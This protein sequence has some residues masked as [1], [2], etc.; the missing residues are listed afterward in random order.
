VLAALT[1]AAMCTALAL[2]PTPQ[3]QAY[4]TFADQRAWLSVPHFLNVVSSAALVLAGAAG[5]WFI[6]GHASASAASTCTQRWD[7]RPYGVF[8]LGALLTGFGS[9]WYHWAPDSARLTWDRLPITLIFMSLLA[10]TVGER[11]SASGARLGL[12]P[13]L[14]LGLASVIFWQLGEQRGAGDL[15]LY[16]L[17]QFHTALMIPLIALLFPS[18]HGGDHAIMQAI[19]LYALAMLC[20]KLLDARIYALGQVVSGHTLKHL[21][22]A[23]AV[24]CVLRM[25]MAR[26]R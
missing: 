9:A 25:L 19:A 12:V 15:R 6:V 3:L 2:P 11:I 10:A 17:V 18:R 21:L 26:P 20:D 5:L 4:H 8:F 16:G 7:H 13:L 22:A 24:A 14:L 23:A 1:L